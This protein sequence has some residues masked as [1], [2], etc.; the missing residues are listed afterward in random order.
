MLHPRVRPEHERI[1]GS[2]RGSESVARVMHQR[3]TGKMCRVNDGIR[4]SE[5]FVSSA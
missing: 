1:E 5:E 3:S 4:F 2:R